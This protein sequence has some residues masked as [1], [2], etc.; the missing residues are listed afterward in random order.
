[1]KKM[2]VIYITD[3]SSGCNKLLSVHKTYS[4]KIPLAGGQMA[5]LF[6]QQLHTTDDWGPQP[7]ALIEYQ[8]KGTRKHIKLD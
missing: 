3:K 7:A 2:N 6:Q 1:M 5:P 4:A 8:Q